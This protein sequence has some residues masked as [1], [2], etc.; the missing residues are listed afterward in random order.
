MRWKLIGIEFHKRRREGY[1]RLD[2]TGNSL[3][4]HHGWWTLEW[5]RGE[6]VDYYR[7]LRR[8]RHRLIRS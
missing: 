1:T 3:L 2:G 6:F 8:Q 4:S 7:A 5:A